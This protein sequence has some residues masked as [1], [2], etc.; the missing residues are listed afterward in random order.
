VRHWRLLLQVGVV[1]V[2]L[3]APYFQRRVAKAY[4]SIVGEGLHLV[5][6]NKGFKAIDISCK[7]LIA[8]TL[9]WLWSSYCESLPLYNL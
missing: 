7:S 5:S 8:P 4:A 6:R 1:K 2:D 9:A 3:G